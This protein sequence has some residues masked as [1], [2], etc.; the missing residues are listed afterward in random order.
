MGAFAF[1]TRAPCLASPT[2]A[3]LV[4]QLLG[5][6]GSESNPQSQFQQWVYLIRS[7]EGLLDD[8]TAK[9]SRPST[10]GGRRS[11]S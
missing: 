7:A 8:R 6:T 1:R 10:S 5:I 9:M 11:R 2:L 4:C 3:R